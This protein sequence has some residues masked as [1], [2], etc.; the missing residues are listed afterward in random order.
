MET[1]QWQ[2]RPT[3][4]D[5]D[6]QHFVY[7]ALALECNACILKTL[8]FEWLHYKPSYNIQ[9]MH[10]A[11]ERAKAELNE[12]GLGPG[13]VNHSLQNCVW[14]LSDGYVKLDWSCRVDHT[15][16]S[17]SIG[18]FT[19]NHRKCV[20]FIFDKEG[21][22]YLHEDKKLHVLKGESMDAFLSTEIQEIV[23]LALLCLGDFT[24]DPEPDARV[25]R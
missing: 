10:L 3:Y 17:F 25:A 23:K 4:S 1:L 16:A 7:F 11:V 21:V 8:A 14:P 19:M 13:Q 6:R 20:I 18:F 15:H 9:F 2:L 22:R 12:A 24:L 5:K